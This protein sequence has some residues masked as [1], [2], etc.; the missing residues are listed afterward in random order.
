MTNQQN[1]FIY[2]R[3]CESA[4]RA[5][6]LQ[7]SDRIQIQRSGPLDNKD[8][9]LLPAGDEG[10]TLPSHSTQTAVLSTID[11][12]HRVLASHLKG[13]APLDS[14]Q[15]YS[16][17]KKKG[18]RTNASGGPAHVQPL[19]N[20]CR[21]T[22]S[23]WEGPT[24]TSSLAAALTAR[25][26]FYYAAALSTGQQVS[27]VSRP[28]AI[29]P[30]RPHHQHN[31]HAPEWRFN[32]I[33]SCHSPL[34][35]Q[36]SGGSLIRASG[37]ARHGTSKLETSQPPTSRAAKPFHPTFILVSCPRVLQTF[38]PWPPRFDH[39]SR[40]EIKGNRFF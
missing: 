29:P 15:L 39:R 17:E 25:Q 7:G 10:R 21:Q 34:K 5:R 27:R 28:R 6:L 4:V 26:R 40:L 11:H 22:S 30:A 38:R 18:A 16:E 36:Q 2:R 19:P 31:P 33:W 14:S 8:A 3:A 23:R 9:P 35:L 24:C 37:A 12:L 13:L 20:R 32:D 1:S